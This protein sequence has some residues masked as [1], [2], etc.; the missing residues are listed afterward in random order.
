MH[1]Q[2][3]GKPYTTQSKFSQNS[4][5]VKPSIGEKIDSWTKD[6]L[7]IY[8]NDFGNKVDLLLSYLQTHV[9]E[10]GT[11]L[12]ILDNLMA[13]DIL[14]LDGDSNQKQSTLIKSITNFAKNYNVHINNSSPKKDYDLPSQD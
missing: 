11:D 12:I 2:A 8:N 14:M 5:Y 7:Y 4:F 13:L 1:L 3:A 10:T 6:K 9:Q